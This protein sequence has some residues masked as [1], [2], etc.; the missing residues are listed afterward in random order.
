MNIEGL[1]SGLLGNSFVDTSRKA[2]RPFRDLLNSYYPL[3]PNVTAAILD[4]RH[5]TRVVRKGCPLYHENDPITF[6]TVMNLGTAFDFKTTGRDARQILSLKRSGEPLCLDSFFKGKAAHGVRAITDVEVID[7][8]RPDFEDLLDR[9]PVV[10]AALTRHLCAETRRLKSWLTN[11]GRNDSYARV[12]NF[13][14]EFASR[15]AEEPCEAFSF[16]LKQEQLGDILGLTAVHINRTL[17]KLV[18]DGVIERGKGWI[19]IRDWPQL[20]ATAGHV[21]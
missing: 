16:P 7:V 21:S 18:A 1:A 3:E 6:F 17:A 11:V 12:A 15:C 20:S 5:L 14:C 19:Q 13:L 9:F 2:L 4:L 10:H 8:S